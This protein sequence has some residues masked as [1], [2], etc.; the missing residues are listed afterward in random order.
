MVQWL[1]IC[2]AGTAEHEGDGDHVLLHISV[3][4][5]CLVGTAEH[6][7]GGDQVLLRSSVAEHL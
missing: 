7:G 3:V 6:E 1:S 4:E 2:E 5:H